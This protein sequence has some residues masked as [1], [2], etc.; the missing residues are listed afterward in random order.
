[1][2]A[3]RLMARLERTTQY[4]DPAVPIRR[5]VP[6]NPDGYEAAQYIHRLRETIGWLVH[7]AFE[8]IEDEEVRQ[9]LATRARNAMEGV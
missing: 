5:I 3:H 7:D 4:L 2:N 6:L 1:M 9:R 8:V